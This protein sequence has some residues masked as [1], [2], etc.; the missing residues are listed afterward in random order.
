MNRTIKKVTLKCFHYES[1][2][3]LWMHLADF[4]A[5]YNFAHQ[6]KTLS[7]LH[8]S[9]IHRQI[10]TL[11]QDSFIVDP[12]DLTPELNN[13]C[14]TTFSNDAKGKH[15]SCPTNYRIMHL[16]RKQ[17]SLETARFLSF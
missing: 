8:P 17:K 13:L 10:R 1:H 4:M 9:R 16:S 11:E 5:A 3:Q 6:L 15:D 14:T 12:L 2:D 7:G